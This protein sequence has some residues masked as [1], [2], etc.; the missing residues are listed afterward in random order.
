MWSPESPQIILVYVS[1]LCDQNSLF[2]KRTFYLENQCIL[3]AGQ[4]DRGGGFRYKKI[5]G[6]SSVKQLI[7]LPGRHTHT[8]GGKENTLTQE[9]VLKTWVKV[10]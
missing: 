10:F 6:G 9:R 4:F 8:Q 3:I 5:S 1:S 7:T 2:N